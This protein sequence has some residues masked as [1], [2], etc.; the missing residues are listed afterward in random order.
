MRFCS[1]FTVGFTFLAIG[2]TSHHIRFSLCVKWFSSSLIL[3]LCSHIYSQLLWL[4]SSPRN[5][6]TV[7]DAGDLSCI[8]AVGTALETEFMKVTSCL[9]GFS[10]LPFI[11]GQHFTC[12]MGFYSL[13]RPFLTGRGG[14][15][16]DGVSCLCP[17]ERR[18]G[19]SGYAVPLVVCYMGTGCYCCPGTKV[20]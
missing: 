15:G 3:R 10:S 9:S 5:R 20:M 6:D 19:G 18:V 7:L 8:S 11:C 13:Q 12:D 1:V 2:T 4:L 14:C 16:C 17:G